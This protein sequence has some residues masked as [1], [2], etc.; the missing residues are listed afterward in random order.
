MNFELCSCPTYG[1]MVSL[2]NYRIQLQN[3][4]PVFL[5]CVINTMRQTWV[6]ILI[7]NYDLQTLLEKNP[8]LTLRDSGIQK[9]ATG[10]LWVRKGEKRLRAKN[11][12]QRLYDDLIK[13]SPR[14][15]KFHSVEADI[16]WLREY[17]YKVLWAIRSTL[18][19]L[20]KC[21]FSSVQLLSRVRLFAI[22]WKA[23]HQTSLSITN[24]LGSLKLTSIK[25]VMPSSHL[26]LCCPLLL[27]PPIPP[28]IRVFSNESTLRMR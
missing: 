7:N 22:P 20:G 11:L 1:L 27:L 24:S 19:S 16:S 9:L 3:L 14:Y 13:S 17:L 18:D 10:S 28:S 5:D 2:L 12:S 6:K 25:S 15:L 23:A 8:P 26:I 4:S 21:V